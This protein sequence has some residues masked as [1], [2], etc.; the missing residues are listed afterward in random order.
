MAQ[1][2]SVLE[3]NKIDHEFIKNIC[4][5]YM[6]DNRSN[7]GTFGRILDSIAN[8]DW[9]AATPPNVPAN[10]WKSIIPLSNTIG[11][12]LI[13][14][15]IIVQTSRDCQVSLS[16]SKGSSSLT[17]SY[18]NFIRT[19]DNPSGGTVIFDF[20]ANPLRVEYDTTGG[21]LYS[22]TGT[23]TVPGINY[24]VSG[25][26]Y[27]ISN[28]TNLNADYHV[29]YMGD[30][31]CNV[32]EAFAREYVDDGTATQG[33]WTII[34]QT[35]LRSLGIDTFRS[36]IGQGGSNIGYWREFA[37]KGL[38]RRWCPD[39]VF[40]NVG[41][42][43]GMTGI[44]GGTSKLWYKEIVRLY[45][46]QNPNGCFCIINVADTDIAEKLAIVP[47]GPH[48]GKTFL[49]AIR[50]VLKEVYNEM[51]TEIPNADLVLADVNPANTYSA[52]D[53]S[54]FVETTAGTRL[55]PN[56]TLG[57]PKL[58]NVINPAILSSRFVQK[59]INP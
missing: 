13:V 32:S 30:S 36:N 39:V 18:T 21:L 35:Y 4:S 31:F 14:E 40:C 55:H 10:T 5:L 48:A 56:T 37:T 49:V 52:S 53:A 29:G 24:Y 12:C 45:F 19:Q 51:L 25:E 16:L 7:V 27:S 8:P 41:I 50:D 15:K 17:Q 20:T 57:Q 43:E 33:Q 22:V 46:K 54:N 2:I 59:I 9:K 26:W 38:F 44:T 3:K 6:S 28:D 42:N 58:A 23:G 11:R 34:T 47:S 1:R